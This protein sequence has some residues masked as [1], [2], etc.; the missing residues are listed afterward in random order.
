MV[1][2]LDLPGTDA[3]PLLIATHALAAAGYRADPAS[4]PTDSHDL[5]VMYLAGLVT[6]LDALGP[7]PEHTQRQAVIDATV[8]A[9]TDHEVAAL[10][11]ALD[12]YIRPY[13]GPVSTGNRTMLDIVTRTVAGAIA[14]NLE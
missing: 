12:G 4:R 3:P 5:A 10:L 11:A 14:D 8:K 1:K 7:N 2:A 6:A 9:P 13:G